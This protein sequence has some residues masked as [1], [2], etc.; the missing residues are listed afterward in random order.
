M[1]RS[2]VYSK[3]DCIWIGQVLKE[4]DIKDRTVVK[5]NKQIMDVSQYL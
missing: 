4:V 3:D 2:N 5:I 1:M